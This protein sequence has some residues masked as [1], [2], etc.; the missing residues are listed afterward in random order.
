M[1]KKPSRDWGDIIED[2]MVHYFLAICLNCDNHSEISAGVHGR[3]YYTFWHIFP[4]VV[5]LQCYL[6]FFGLLINFGSYCNEIFNSKVHSSVS[7]VMVN[8]SYLMKLD[9][10][11]SLFPEILLSHNWCNFSHETILSQLQLSHTCDL[12]L[13]GM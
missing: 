9:N 1:R 2:S 10:N 13:L 4:P 3:L 8:L 5:N 6:R 12:F 7:H 11:I